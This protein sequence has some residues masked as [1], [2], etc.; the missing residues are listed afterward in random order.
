MY[1]KFGYKKVEIARWNAVKD[2]PSCMKQCEKGKKRVELETLLAFFFTKTGYITQLLLLE[3][4]M[5]VYH[6]R[7]E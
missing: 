4:N 2:A 1:A 3:G 6:P 7:N 5:S